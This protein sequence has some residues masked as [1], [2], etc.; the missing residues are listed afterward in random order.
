M[1]QLPQQ[2]VPPNQTQHPEY[3]SALVPLVL[4]NG[5]QRLFGLRSSAPARAI[6]TVD[7]VECGTAAEDKQGSVIA[8]LISRTGLIACALISE[9]GQVVV[10]TRMNEASVSG[11][12]GMR[13]K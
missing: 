1:N 6:G 2:R 8:Q 7:L 4:R 13:A 5:W 9:S 11:D 10:Q 12:V 3:N